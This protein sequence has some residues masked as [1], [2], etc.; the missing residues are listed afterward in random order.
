[1]F[2]SIIRT[3]VI[4]FIVIFA[5]RVMGKRQVGDLQPGELVI[6]ILISEIAAMPLQDG[7]APILVGII[8]I[9]TLVVAEI[10]V[11]F[12]SMKF[13]FIRRIINGS[14][15][16]II[17]DG[18]IDQKLLKKLRVTAPDVMEVLRG[19]EVFDISS[20]SYAILET[21]GSLSVMLR[22][23]ERTAT[24][25]NLNGTPDNSKMPFLVVSDGDIIKD[26][27]KL[28][29]TDEG[30]I[31]RTLNKKKIQLKDVF[32]MTMDSDGNTDI[33]LKEKK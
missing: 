12:L 24:Q 14:S 3:I 11:S 30:A 8:A 16:V 13:L 4:Y 10:L 31:K 29:K 7:N 18:V 25:K 2:S 22:P 20:V 5:V 17:K 15:A 19:Q 6:T 26:E 23:D 27:L 28:I 32:I 33:I 21:N 1:M 9:L